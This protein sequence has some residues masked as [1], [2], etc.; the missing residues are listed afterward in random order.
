M[1]LGV[2]SKQKIVIIALAI[3]LFAMAQYFAIE[4]LS[5]TNQKKMSEIY[6]N[7]YDQGLNDAVNTLFDQTKDC[8][9]TTIF[10]GNMSKQIFDVSCL[11]NESEKLLP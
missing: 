5:E 4:K 9:I 7:G 1:Q 2:I 3:A 10:A 6:Q 8:Q 11:Q